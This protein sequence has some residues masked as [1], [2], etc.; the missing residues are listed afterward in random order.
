MNVR[1]SYQCDMQLSEFMDDRGLSDEDVAEAISVHPKTIYR[2]RRH[3][4]R[5]GWDL[6]RL[7][8]KWS[9]GAVQ[10]NDWADDQ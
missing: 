9:S 4:M 10:P 5:P 7:I 2:Y 8:T 3:M 1:M 6:I